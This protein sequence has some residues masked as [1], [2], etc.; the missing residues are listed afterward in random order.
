[1]NTR[2]AFASTV[3]ARVVSRAG[4]PGPEP[5]NMMRPGLGLRPRVVICVSPS[6]FLMR[7]VSPPRRH[8]FPFPQFEQLGVHREPKLWC[9]I[10]TADTGRA[11]HVGSVQRLH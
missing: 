2:G 6:H 8:E 7:V 11:D 4:S 5:T 3:A 9:P 1:M 10:R